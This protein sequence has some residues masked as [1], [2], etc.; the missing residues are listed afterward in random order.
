MAQSAA[1][2][3]RCA[4]R[5]HLLARPHPF[6]RPFHRR[7]PQRR[8]ALA[9]RRRIPA[10]AHRQLHGAGPR[11]QGRQRPFRRH[12]H[13]AVARPEVAPPPDPFDRRDRG[14]LEDRLAPHPAR[15]GAAK[16]SSRPA[17]DDSPGQELGLPRIRPQPAGTYR[18]LRSSHSRP[19]IMVDHYRESG[20]GRMLMVSKSMSR[21][22]IYLAVAGIASIGF[23]VITLFWPGITLVA[24]TVLFG[25]LTLVYG[26]VAH[27]AALVTLP[28]R[29]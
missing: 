19:E 7:R 9:H 6:Q 16:D 15:P 29:G 12:P 2:V 14:V 13:P 18:V 22:A 4:G 25:A 24:L 3:A 10:R 20:Q 8:Q 26:A 28:C 1:R 21:T 5:A 11:G 27:A 17:P 23:G